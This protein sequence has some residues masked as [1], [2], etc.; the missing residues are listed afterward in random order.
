M[1][2]HEHTQIIMHGPFP[3]CHEPAQIFHLSVIEFTDLQR[4]LNIK[5][6]KPGCDLLKAADVLLN[7]GLILPSFFYNYGNHGPGHKRVG[8]G[9]DRQIH[10][11]DFR[12]LRQSR[13][14]NDQ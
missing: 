14:D 11:G 10:I 5:I 1:T 3:R 12:N 4:T 6:R 8:S 2:I 7:E 9:T 13:I